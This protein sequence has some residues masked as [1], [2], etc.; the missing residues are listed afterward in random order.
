MD[1]HFRRRCGFQWSCPRG[2]NLL[3]SLLSSRTYLTTNYILTYL[4]K[5]SPELEN[6]FRKH[7]QFN[8]RRYHFALQFFT[9]WG[10]NTY[11][12]DL[13][14]YCS[15][16]PRHQ[17]NTISFT[18]Q[19]QL[20][21]ALNHN[22]PEWI[23]PVVQAL[24]YCHSLSI[25][26][27]DWETIPPSIVHEI[28]TLREEIWRNRTCM[29]SYV[30]RDLP[31]IDECRN[32]QN[33]QPNPELQHVN[34]CSAQALL[35]YVSVVGPKLATLRLEPPEYENSE[36]RRTLEGLLD[37]HPASA[38][39]VSPCYRQWWKEQLENGESRL[40]KRFAKELESV[41]RAIASIT[42][43]VTPERRLWKADD[44]VV[45]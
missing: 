13:L 24:A 30:P 18:Y 26:A 4:G 9:T 22:T 35:H 14:D 39:L 21:I 44:A 5:W 10:I 19:L 36:F 32:A 12:K 1:Q 41:E 20:D 45:D 7:R 40:R 23:A 11:R 8:G 25:K 17:L 3:L 43:N 29:M 2:S 6:T 37:S 16:I 42:S 34:W 38:V 33:R 27:E 31:M 28:T 15:R